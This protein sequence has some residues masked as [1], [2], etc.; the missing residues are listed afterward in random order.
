MMNFE[1][2][3]SQNPDLKIYRADSPEFAEYGKLRTGYELEPVF[4][5]AETVAVPEQGNLYRASDPEVES[6]PVIRELM[7]DIYGGSPAQAGPCC[8][9]NQVLNGIEYHVGSETAIAVKPCVLF[10]GRL[11]DMAGNTYD[12]GLTEAFYVEPGQIVQLYETTL[13]YTPC[14]VEDCFFTVCMLPKGT[15]DP[16]PGGRRGI[17]KSQNKWFLAHPDNLQKVQA[18]DFPGLLGKMKKL[19][20]P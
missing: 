13:H 9:R 4:R 10:L 3:C 8:G 6:I 2:L 18:G 5:W 1:V 15:G 14:R 20:L 12:G 11:R 16:L 17:L 19:R 7:T